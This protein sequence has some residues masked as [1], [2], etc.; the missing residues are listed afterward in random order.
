MIIYKVEQNWQLRYVEKL[1][2]IGRGASERIDTFTTLLISPLKRDNIVI[3][4]CGDAT[5]YVEFD[6]T[7]DADRFKEHIQ[8]YGYISKEEL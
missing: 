3:I 4:V 5:L 1:A 6:S 8:L 7:T 2:K